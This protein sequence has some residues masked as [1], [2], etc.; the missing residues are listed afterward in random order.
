MNV[1]V[2]FYW[3]RH[4]HEHICRK[5]SYYE[6]SKKWIAAKKFFSK[7]LSVLQVLFNSI[8]GD[9]VRSRKIFSIM[10]SKILS[11]SFHIKKKYSQLSFLF[12]IRK[13]RLIFPYFYLSEFQSIF[14][15]N[16]LRGTLS[17]NWESRWTNTNLS[18]KLNTLHIQKINTTTNDCGGRS[19]RRITFHQSHERSFLIRTKEG[20]TNYS[21]LWWNAINLCSKLMLLSI[22]DNI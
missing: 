11:D 16:R 8:N 2:E 20:K 21:Q 10:I 17:N 7:F 19:F 12:I 9:I 22:H 4:S 18:N 13:S 15:T 5:T 6:W 1:E 14:Q 3:F